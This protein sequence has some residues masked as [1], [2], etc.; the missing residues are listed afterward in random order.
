MFK[1]I[2]SIGLLL[3]LLLFAIPGR[4][5]TRLIFPRIVFQNGLFSGIA[6]SNPTGAAASIK[7]TAYYP[8]GTKLAD[9]IPPADLP[10]GGQY[11][12]LASQVFDPTNTLAGST[13][14]YFWVEVTST[15]SGLAGFYIEG[16]NPT[17]FQY[18]GDLGTFGTDLYLPAVENTGT[19]V[20]EISLVNADTSVNGGDAIVTVD[21][22]KAD[23]TKVDSKSVVIAKAASLQGPLASIPAFNLA[24][25]QVVAL[26][27]HSDRPVLCYGIVRPPLSGKTPIA[28]PAED[29]N[30]PAKTLYFPQLADG[31]DWTTSLGI[32]NLDFSAQTLVNITAYDKNGNVFVDPTITNPK[33]VAIPPGGLLQSSFKDL[34]PFT[35]TSYKEGWLKV[36]AN[37][38]SINGFVQYGSGN[39]RA[40]VIAQLNSFQLSMF[41]HQAQAPTCS[42]CPSYFTGLAVLNSGSLAANVEIF[43]LGSQGNTVGRIQTVLKPGQRTS[44]LLYQL[45]SE[46]ENKNGGSVFVRS[47]RPV[48]TT[49]LF[50]VNDNNDVIALANVP[51]QQVTASFHPTSTL[52]TITP[53]PPL[54]VIE[55]GK[56]RQFLSPGV[57]GVQW[58]VVGPPGIDLGTISSSGLY[59][60]P[61]KAP[62]PRTLTIQAS[63]STG[64]NSGA[65]SIDVVQREQLTGGLTLVTAVAYFENLQRFFVAEQQVLS[66][67]PS[68]GFA[69][70][71]TNTQISEVTKSGSTATNSP[72]LSISGDS[73][74][75]MLPYDDG[76]N[77]YLLLAGQNTGKIYRLDVAGKVL[78]TVVSGLNQ[79]T[80][81]AL[82]PT[83]GNLL[84]AEA[85]AGQITVV[86]ASQI[87]SASDPSVT[88]LAP[89]GG[90]RLQAIAV[91]GIQGIAIDKCT[92]TV[93]VTLTDG[94]LHEYQG[95]S[96]RVVET[97]LDKPTQLQALYRDGFSCANGLTLG[98]V[99]ASRVSLSYPK[100]LITRTTLIDGILGVD[101]ITFFPKGNPFTTGGEASVGIA[102]AST[103]PAQGQVAD[104][105]MGG[106]YQSVPPVTFA[107]TGLF[108]GTG[109][110]ADPIGDT[111]NGDILTQLGYSVPDIVSVTGSTQGGQSVITI[112]FAAPVTL[113][114]ISAT[115]QP[116]AD[117]LWAFIFM[118]T[119]AGTAVLSQY[120]IPISINFSDYFPFGNPGLFLFDSFLGVFYG[121]AF[122]SSVIGQESLVTVSAI[123]NMVTLSVP[124]SALDLNGTTAIVMVGSGGIFSDVAPNN[125]VLK[126][127]P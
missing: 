13:P 12:N 78:K 88:T 25:D 36:D 95:S 71:T 109:P 54:A 69:A 38:P 120:P 67:A 119:T 40:L 77:H 108:G 106:I 56:T 94:T 93:Y 32:A 44:Q 42:G 23:G 62:A 60:A 7:L 65:S 123:G 105:P 50:A 17:T 6:I 14:K 98:I 97:G 76:N 118:N 110:N 19:T 49:E 79:P 53:T 2:R 111:F 75:K 47:D 16:N 59:T 124:T 72:F 68:I 63:A 8:D 52:A 3:A 22:L 55:T 89:G 29:V 84:V 107:S 81:M 41:S 4:A 70:T 91:A 26:R 102:V 20:T 99:E 33:S 28:L 101:D 11:L 57:S 39:N 51:P 104:V 37:S 15:T 1:Q 31:G 117:G 45:V 64:N 34:F 46:S 126:L 121:E 103:T 112:K 85:G 127:G 5:D 61:I 21:F 80:S 35:D 115:G 122:Y 92:G 86:T 83:T 27:V 125:G 66:G 96:N 90:R 73:I 114:T 82:D 74:A 18:G 48:F 58:S 24:F 9:V 30:N 43:S 116:S 10:S 100:A 113:G 87:A